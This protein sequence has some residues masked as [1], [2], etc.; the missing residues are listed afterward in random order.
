M[1]WAKRGQILAAAL[2]LFLLP[3]Q[4]IGDLRV[5]FL[6][7]EAF[8]PEQGEWV[9][10]YRYRVPVILGEGEAEASIRDYYDLALSEML[11]LV[12][13]MYAAD[14][15]MAGQGKQEITQDYRVTCN[16]AR[17]FSTL[18][19]QNQTVAGENLTTLRS[20]VFAVSGDFAGETLTLR[21]LLMVGE[22]S[23]Q[24][25]GLVLEDVYRRIQVMRETDTAWLEMDAE[26]L[27]AYFY[28]E[29]QFYADEENRA[30]FYLQPGDLRRDD[31]VVTF[32]YTK[33]Q[34]QMLIDSAE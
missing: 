33:D 15:D 11:S 27:G 12:L 7:G 24:L 29:T 14:P 10:H 34:M 16:D 31:M 6:E 26:T 9:Y 20:Q 4:A 32:S 17:F 18:M 23:S 28:P 5:D 22:D 3:L 13:P 8:F 2:L 30:V 1:R 19:T 21:G 25:A